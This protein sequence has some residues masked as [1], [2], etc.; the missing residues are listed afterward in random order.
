MT[1]RSS[2]AG[3]GKKYIKNT[4]REAVRVENHRVGSYTL[5]PHFSRITYS[6]RRLT[7]SA[8]SSSVV[9]GVLLAVVG[10]LLAGCQ[11]VA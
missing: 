11:N 9:V 6:G 5:L 1:L 8:N 7:P 3:H 2:I 10:V 4:G